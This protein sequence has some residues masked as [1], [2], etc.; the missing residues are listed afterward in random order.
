MENRILKWATP[1]LLTMLVSV[2]SWMA[3]E[4]K[5]NQEMLWGEQKTINKEQSKFNQTV[6]SELIR[7]D[8]RINQLIKLRNNINQLKD[9][10]YESK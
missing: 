9:K 4:Y 6:E 10:E 1:V 8:E 2:V 5:S 3:L 7:H